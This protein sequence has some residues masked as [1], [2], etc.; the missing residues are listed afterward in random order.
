MNAIGDNLQLHRQCKADHSKAYRAIGNT[1]NMRILLHIHSV[2]H[3]VEYSA[4]P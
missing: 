2:P 3:K 4:L 1:T